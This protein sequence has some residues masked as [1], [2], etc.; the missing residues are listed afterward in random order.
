[1]LYLLYTDYMLRFGGAT[2]RFTP[3]WVG[4]KKYMRVAKKVVPK[5]DSTIKLITALLRVL[6][7]SSQHLQSVMTQKM[8]RSLNVSED[9]H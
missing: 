2:T 9:A 6:S 7:P 4:S 3:T 5:L 8:Y 1:M